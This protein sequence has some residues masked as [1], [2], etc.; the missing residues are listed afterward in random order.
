MSELSD[1][2]SGGRLIGVGASVLPSHPIAVV[3]VSTTAWRK[4]LASPPGLLVWLRSIE[5]AGAVKDDI[6]FVVAIAVC[7]FAGRT[8]AEWREGST[9]GEGGLGLE[10]GIGSLGK[11]GNLWMDLWR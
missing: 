1:R 6:D 10:L 5:G 3:I 9:L 4:V 8:G 11:L 2:S 7:S